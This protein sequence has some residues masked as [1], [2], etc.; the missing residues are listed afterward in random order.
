M[1]ATIIVRDHRIEKNM[2]VVAVVINGEVEDY[3]MFDRCNLMVGP[4]VKEY[5]NAGYEIEVIE[6]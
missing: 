1:K 5:I 3:R 6:Q 4:I 2:K